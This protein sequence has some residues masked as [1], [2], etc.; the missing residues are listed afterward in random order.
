MTPDEKYK[1]LF[2]KMMFNVSGHSL[3]V[4]RNNANKHII[5]LCDEVQKE[6]EEVG[7]KR[8]NFWDDVKL[9]ATIKSKK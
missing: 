1:E 9:L 8:T 3:L 2:R 7:F 5:I 6:R 4:K